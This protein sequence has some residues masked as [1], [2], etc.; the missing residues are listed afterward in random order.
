MT[1]RQYLVALALGTAIS[2]SAWCIVMLAIDPAH[3]GTLGFVIFYVTLGAG[4]AGLFTIVGTI[5]RARKYAEDAVQEVVARSFRQGLMLSGLF[6]ACL[7]LLSRGLFSFGT[8]LLLIVLVGLVEFLM[9]SLKR[10]T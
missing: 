10:E 4:I 3:A 9:L 7:A 1:L 2:I 5:V 6:L 8:M